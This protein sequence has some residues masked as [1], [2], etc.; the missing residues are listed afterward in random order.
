[1]PM[2]IVEVGSKK[3][4]QNTRKSRVGKMPQN[5]PKSLVVSRQKTMNEFVSKGPRVSSAA[6][7]K[8]DEEH[9]SEHAG[10]SVAE[11]IK[12]FESNCK[13]W[14]NKPDLSALSSTSVISPKKS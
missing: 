11:K 7:R 4:P 13:S 12:F 14:L 2:N 6:K 5:V 8:S 10:E 1:M 3:T 9:E